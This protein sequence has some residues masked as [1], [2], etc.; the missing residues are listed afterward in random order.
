MDA[1][2]WSFESISWKLYR[3]PQLRRQLVIG[4]QL[5]AVDAVVSPH[6]ELGKCLIVRVIEGN[7]ILIGGPRSGARQGC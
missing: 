1:A 5:A 7:V 4:Y 2:L 3:V 6:Q